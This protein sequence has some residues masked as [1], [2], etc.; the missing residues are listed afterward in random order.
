[1]SRALS[2]RAALTTVTAA[3][4]ASGCGTAPS[5]AHKPTAHHTDTRGDS[6]APP[7][8]SSLLF[9][10]AVAAQHFSTDPADYPAQ[11][12]Q[13]PGAYDPVCDDGWAVASISRPE[14]G[15][16]DGYTLF[17][18]ADGKWVYTAQVGGIQADC[19]LEQQHVPVSVAQALWPPSHSLGAS[20]CTQNG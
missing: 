4:I 15:T 14:V 11:T 7:C 17:R 19:I 8:T 12:G 18:A 2:R 13:A 3:I 5:S 6:S 1:M 16:T 10:A 9:G 20:Y